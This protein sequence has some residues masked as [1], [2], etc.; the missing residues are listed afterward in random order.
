MANV[1]T[2]AKAMVKMADSAG[3]MRT[4]GYATGIQITEVLLNG[5]IDSLGFIDTREL[6]LIGRQVTATVNFI[7]IFQ[8]NY[9]DTGGDGPGEGTVDEGVSLNTE[10]SVTATARARTDNAF[11]IDKQQGFDLEIVD[12]QPNDGANERVIYTLKG[13]KPSAHS[14]VVD[15]GSLM[16]VQVSLDA[17]YLI[18]N[19]GPFIGD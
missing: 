7:R 12:T 13:C 17:L 19:E 14:I 3:V 9:A 16:G 5:R 2:G 10:R 11:A 8:T 4:V 18:R 6:A 1:I 15:R